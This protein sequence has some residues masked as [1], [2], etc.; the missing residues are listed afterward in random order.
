MGKDTCPKGRLKSVFR[1]PFVLSVSIVAW[2]LPTK[3]AGKRG[4]LK[5]W[6]WFVGKAYDMGLVVVRGWN[7]R[8][9]ANDLIPP[10]NIRFIQASPPPRTLPSTIS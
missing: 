10:C 8:Y 6:V 4:R 5:F 9:A 2:A 1:R 7:Q 3:M